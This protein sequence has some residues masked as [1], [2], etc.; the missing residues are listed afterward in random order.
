M[1]SLE[2]MAGTTAPVRGA[3]IQLADARAPKASARSSQ[4]GPA[5]GLGYSA[6]ALMDMLRTS[7]TRAAALAGSITSLVRLGS[8]I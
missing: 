4:P 3:D 7:S 1:H 5:P 6:W 8:R 2:W